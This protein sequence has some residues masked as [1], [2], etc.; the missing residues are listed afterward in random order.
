MLQNFEREV[1]KAKGKA[2]SAVAEL[3]D[4]EDALDAA[5]SK[6]SIQNWVNLGFYTLISELYDF[7]SYY[8]QILKLHLY[9]RRTVQLTF[10]AYYFLNYC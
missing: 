6:V 5:E 4:L 9:L 10:C 2:E 3:D 7:I 8:E 1:E